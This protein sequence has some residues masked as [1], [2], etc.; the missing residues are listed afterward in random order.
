[1][2]SNTL[3]VVTQGDAEK[4]FQNLIAD[5]RPVSFGHI[6]DI[7]EDLFKKLNEGTSSD[8]IIVTEFNPNHSR[9]AAIVKAFRG[10][11]RESIFVT[12]AH[13]PVAVTDCFDHIF[14]F[15]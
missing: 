7:P 3:I 4:L 1:M 6:C 5:R 9:A 8:D 12:N 11:Y 2:K 13:V 15:K 14:S 10:K